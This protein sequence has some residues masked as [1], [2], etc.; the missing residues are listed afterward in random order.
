RLL[1][2]ERVAG[3]RLGEVK[4]VLQPGRAVGGKRDLA[5]HT[6]QARDRVGAGQLHLRALDLAGRLD[7]QQFAGEGAARPLQLPADARHA[8]AVGVG[9]YVLVASLA[10]VGPA[11]QAAAWVGEQVL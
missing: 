11:I 6:A 8:V 5:P 9:E 1:D 4:V 2:R 7:A 10:E 3:Y